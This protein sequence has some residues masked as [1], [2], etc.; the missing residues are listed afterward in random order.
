[1]FIKK[2]KLNIWKL[3]KLE[4]LMGLD[5]LHNSLFLTY[6]SNLVLFHKSKKAKEE[7]EV[8]NFYAHKFKYVQ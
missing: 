8:L 4:K 2:N 3:V 5:K 6:Q 1:M 7:K